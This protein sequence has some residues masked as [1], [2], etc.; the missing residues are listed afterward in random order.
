MPQS[1]KWVHLLGRAEQKLVCASPQRNICL[2]RNTDDLCVC[3]G[4]CSVFNRMPL[5]INSG[6]GSRDEKKHSALEKL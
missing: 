5:N 4:I 1:Q 6:L 2:H 3:F